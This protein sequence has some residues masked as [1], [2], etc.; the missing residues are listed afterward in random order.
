MVPLN[1]SLVIMNPPFTTPTNHAADHAKP[2]NPAFAA[3]NTTLDEQKTM[4]EK[5]KKLSR[6]TIGDGNAGLGSQFTAIAHNMVMPGGHIALI[7][8]ISAMIG[9][10]DDDKLGTSWQKLR[11]LLADNY[12]DIIVITIAK[13]AARDSTFSADTNL[14]EII[15][16]ARRLANNE[17]PK[18]QAYFVNLTERPQNKLAAQ[19]IA[20][21]I[22]QTIAESSN[23]G[24]FSDINVGDGSAGN[25]QLRRIAPAE[26]WTTV[27]IANLGL[28]HAAEELAQG[29][30][31]LPQRK[32]PVSVP[33]TQMGTIGNVGP[34]HRD[35]D[36][37]KLE[38]TRGPFTK[39]TGCRTVTASSRP[40]ATKKP[41]KSGA[42]QATC[43]S[44]TNAALAPVPHAPYLLNRGHSAAELGPATAW[45]T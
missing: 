27:R 14:A 12:N 39:H 35:I 1:Q 38:P 23:I 36:G 22:R 13:A 11:R 8:P 41:T 3:F 17:K 26:K 20:K 40:D 29:R 18:M 28:V 43:I 9:G 19:E 5:T 7:L 30:L 42:A 4:S 31:L 34:L 2:G 32:A 21:S 15:V 37:G 44:A 16:V 24:S 6:G 33:M 25:L 45:R 10:S